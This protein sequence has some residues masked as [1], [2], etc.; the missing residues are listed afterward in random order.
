[1]A[2]IYRTLV[3]TENDDVLRFTTE[4]S[5]DNEIYYTT[6]LGN[7]GND[8][9]YVGADAPPL[10]IDAG[11][12]DDTI[13][14]LHQ[15]EFSIISGGTGDDLVAYNNLST[16]LASIDGGDGY[17]TLRIN[18]TLKSGMFSGFEALSV[19]A[20]VYVDDFDM[21]SLSAISIEKSAELT[22]QDSA[23]LR[24][25]DI[26]TGKAVLHID[27]SWTRDSF[28]LSEATG[29][30]R[31]DAGRGNDTI[32]A[33]E[34]AITAVG[35]RG[36]DSIV[37]SERNDFLAG[38]TGSLYQLQARG[39]DTVIGLGGNDTLV[40][41]SEDTQFDGGDGEDTVLVAEIFRRA[42]DLT[43]LVATNAEKLVLKFAP[44]INVDNASLEQF[45]M[46]SGS[47]HLTFAEAADI[48]ALNFHTNSHLT[49]TGSSEDDSI[50]LAG[51]Y[52]RASI[53]GG[54][55]DDILIGSERANFIDAGDGDDMVETHGGADRVV[56]NGGADEIHT[57]GG[58]DTIG[59]VS[60]GAG[61]S[62]T[63]YAGD[64]K[65][66]L[67][68]SSSGRDGAQNLYLG[69]GGDHLTLMTP[70]SGG[71]GR[72]D[73]GEDRDNLR[74]YGSL[75]GYDVV[76]IEVLTV[77]N[78]NEIKAD[79]DTFDGFSQI[80]LKGFQEY[81]Y[82]DLSLSAAGSFTWKH[83]SSNDYT[84][85]TL[86]GSSGDDVVDFSEAGR[87]WIFNMGA[88]DDIATGSKKTNIISG[89][90]GDDIL[91]GGGGSD[92]IDGGSGA[93]RFVYRDTEKVMTIVD[94][95]PDGDH[96]TIEISGIAGFHSLADFHGRVTTS[97]NDLVIVFDP[98]A[99]DSLTQI[100]NGI[101]LRNGRDLSLDA[102]M[103]I[104]S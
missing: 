9:I 78:E 80:R 54:L 12:G 22:F 36:D 38:D 23:H 104:F 10:T 95:N 21:S 94:F 100:E 57:G 77:S 18:G 49:I 88:G 79:A 33:G 86:T 31:I 47:A 52:I 85:G 44:Q 3:G 74:L 87:D 17:D 61:D 13:Y 90:N 63:I 4:I 73:G 16:K 72:I 35:G 84:N 98:E 60:H 20:T 101:V 43:R 42:A 28:D 37:G 81:R 68:V 97:G 29:R 24:D 40:F 15:K 92:W 46:I 96:D 62:Q 50:S 19:W 30:I 66:M 67:S 26:V 56:T 1:M 55:G 48:E 5:G 25:V 82:F 83:A 71:E 93:D 99:P 2:I 39:Y 102:G 7:G 53:E 69:A 41:S 45:Q 32:I 70:A 65:D 34:N 91:S 6:I 51:D 14:S 59:V 8:A 58:K 75:A 89:E 64:G 76:N 103:F 11:D 27:G